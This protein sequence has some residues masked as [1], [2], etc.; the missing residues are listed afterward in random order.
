MYIVADRAETV[1]IEVSF[2]ISFYCFFS[3][4]RKQHYG[5]MVLQNRF[6]RNKIE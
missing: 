3:T 4:F 2:D 5:E 6:E 1:H